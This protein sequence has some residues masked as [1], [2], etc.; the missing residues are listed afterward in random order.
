MGILNPAARQYS[1]HE[2]T[3]GSIGLGMT[4]KHPKGIPFIIANEVAERFS[5]YG[6]KAILV[7]FMTTM[8]LDS[9]GVAAPMPEEE[10]TFWYHVFGMGNYLVPAFGAVVA[11]VLWGKYRTIILLSLV[12]CA[13]HAALAIDDTRMGLAIGLALIAIGSGGIKPCV[14][15]HLGDQYREREPGA[16]SQGYALFYLGINVGAC[17]STIATPLLLERY[18]PRAAF[19]VPGAFMALATVVF[20]IGRRRYVVVAPTPWRLYVAE[21]CKGQR[22]R[23]VWTLA[24]LYVSLSPFWALFDQTGSSWILQAE[25]MHREFYI[26]LVGSVTILPSQLQ[27]LNPVL[28]LVLAPLCGWIAYPWLAAR[29]WL[30]DQGKLVVG[31]IIAAA[32]FGIVAFAQQRIAAGEV[33]SVGWQA[34]AYLILTLAEVMVSITALELAYVHAPA[35][36]KSFVTSFYLLSVA[37]GNGVTAALT[38]LLA[39]LACP[40]DTPLYFALFSAMALVSAVPVAWSMKRLSALKA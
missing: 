15:A 32:S 12:Y 18:G 11:D 30:S 33:V 16:L 37:L 5:Y 28:I 35:V 40:P 7:V 3:Q 8:L 38:K 1:R 26:P 9:S 14:S 19:G 24:L 29:G 39:S 34:A 36:S 10:A 27:A 6:M 31:M 4:T 17:L 2:L 20:W 13:G 23:G 22:R 21:L 25:R